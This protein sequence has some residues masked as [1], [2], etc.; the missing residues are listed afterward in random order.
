MNTIFSTGD[1]GKAAIATD[2]AK[3]LPQYTPNIDNLAL[4]LKTKTGD[5]RV[6]LRNANIMWTLKEFNMTYQLVLFI[7]GWTTNLK[8]ETPASHT[9]MFRAYS[10]RGGVNFVVKKALCTVFEV[11]SCH[12]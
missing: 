10:C 7:S 9:E 1:L 2:L 11:K 12:S 8:A 5:I 4:I 6:P 3:P